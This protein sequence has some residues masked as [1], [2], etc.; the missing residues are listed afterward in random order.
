LNSPVGVGLVV[1]C[2]GIVV[3]LLMKANTDWKRLE[4]EKKEKKQKGA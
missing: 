3:Y 1:L 4:E 2:L